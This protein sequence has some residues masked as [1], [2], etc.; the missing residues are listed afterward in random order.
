MWNILK[1]SALTRWLSLYTHLS[2]S[3]AARSAFGCYYSWYKM[4]LIWALALY[5]AQHNLLATVSLRNT[6]CTP[7]LPRPLLQ[8]DMSF[9]VTYGN[10]CV[11][12]QPNVI[13]FA[14]KN[15]F[16][17]EFL[18]VSQYWKEEKKA[19]GPCSVTV[20]YRT[21]SLV[22]N[23]LSS[24]CPVTQT[25]T[26]KNCSKIVYLWAEQKLWTAFTRKVL[27][28]HQFSINCSM[29]VSIAKLARL[30]KLM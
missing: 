29:L 2:L 3:Q 23:F 12:V 20:E 10:C 18:R 19:F 26:I 9:H 28:V 17:R 22:C 6:S 1:Q 11:E 30:V 4:P 8:P 13:P 15:H 24:F 27:A 16:Q 21:S 25:I 7:V 5:A 14:V